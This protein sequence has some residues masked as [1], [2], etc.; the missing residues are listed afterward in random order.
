[1]S[2]K[3]EGNGKRLSPHTWAEIQVRYEAGDRVTDLARA[4]SL[5]AGTIS[6]RASR[7]GWKKA[8]DIYNEAMIEARE[9]V[10]EKAKSAYEARIEKASENHQKL[11]AFSQKFAYEMLQQL[12]MNL[13]A[14]KFE[15]EEDFHKQIAAAKA[16]G[17][18]M[19]K[20]SPR[21]FF[22]SLGKLPYEVQAAYNMLKDAVMSERI[23]IWADEFD[24]FAGME[25]ENGSTERL[26][27]IFKASRITS[28]RIT[29]GEGSHGPAENT[30]AEEPI[31]IDA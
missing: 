17:D 7:Y 30:G 5:S 14:V 20:F 22:R 13:D 19:S 23:V 16:R 24:P 12:I 8:K 18:D 26:I 15:R 9:S 2:S 25:E 3:G 11:F 4:Y 21:P 10:K 6:D 29:T 27:E 1:M 28:R 31:E